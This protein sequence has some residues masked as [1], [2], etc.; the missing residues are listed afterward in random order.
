MSEEE[1]DDS[2]DPELHKEEQRKL[3][4]SRDMIKKYPDPVRREWAVLHKLP[5]KD[6]YKRRSLVRQ[7]VRE[8][9]K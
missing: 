3:F 7:L 4:K 2:L 9:G 6:G 1:L 8:R 5:Y